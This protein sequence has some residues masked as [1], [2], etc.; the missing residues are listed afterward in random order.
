VAVIGFIWDV[1]WHIDFGRDRQLFT[2]PHVLILTGL[3]GI[4]AAGV[5]AIGL[6]S[7]ERAEVWRRFG[8]LHVPVSG[9][10]LVVLSA[11]AVL[12]FPLDDLWHRAY[13]IDV[14]MWGPTHLL[15]I[16][17]ASLTPIAL[18]LLYA[19]GGGPR[20]AGRDQTI[21]RSILAM[22]LLL[23]L[24]T[25]QLEFDLGVPQWQVL[26]HPVLIAIAAS[27][28]LVAARAAFGRG[29]AV[30]AAVLFLAARGLLAL[31]IHEG[32]RHTMPRF[33]LY[34]GVAI[35][36]EVVF[37]MTER[38][39]PVARGVLA[40]ISAGTVGLA[41]EWGWTHVFGRVPWETSLLRSIWIA[42]LVAVA[43]SVIGVAMG[44]VLSM[45]RASISA[46]VLVLAGLTLVAGLAA[47]YP[48]HGQRSTATIRTSFVGTSPGVTVVAADG[49]VSTERPVDVTVTMNPADAAR[50][51]DWFV[52]DS[53]QGGHLI[54]TK[55]VPSGSGTY[56]ADGPVPT[57][58][59]WKSL[60]VLFKHDVVA[61][62]P[63]WVPGDLQYKLPVIP[64]VP[65]RTAPMARA[66]RL[67]T[68]E[69]HG[70]AAWPA[71]VAYTGLLGTVL[72]W[73]ALLV[74]AFS[75]LD[76]RDALRAVPAR[77]L[78]QPA[79]EREIRRA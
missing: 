69:S 60:V 78:H 75:V 4:G 14:T 19:E 27:V 32:L 54:T 28:G 64:V 53:W 29:W 43:G 79:D 7:V 11:G 62:A 33:P 74:F 15:M 68:R 34:V 40:G 10:A 73:L 24:S 8:P 61:A 67:L 45:R 42:V 23:G 5:F 63:V 55:L 39:S 58:G 31:V 38:R 76:R 6:A 1:S 41:T 56:R 51:A 48:R 17:G 47:A 49:E 13:G 18:L 21:L 12:G 9:A 57:G 36:V 25:F 59:S 71:I 22:A 20:L 46:P 50:D 44:R 30:R 26:Y 52:I 65:V 37:A 2:P 35:V 77:P 66:T 70:G 3:L 72:V 16:G